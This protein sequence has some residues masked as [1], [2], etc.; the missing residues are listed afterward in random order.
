[1]N[2]EEFNKY[3]N[4][5]V[6]QNDS[7]LVSATNAYQYHYETPIP[8]ELYHAIAMQCCD[9]YGIVKEYDKMLDILDLEY[10]YLYNFSYN[11]SD[12]KMPVEVCIM[13]K[14][15]GLHSGLILEYNIEVDALQITGLTQLSNKNGC[16][17]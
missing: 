9:Y 5:N 6:I 13:H 12:Q 16:K 3:R 11:P 15:Y 14:R 4:R 1:M 2:Y 7:T 17:K 10:E 8:D